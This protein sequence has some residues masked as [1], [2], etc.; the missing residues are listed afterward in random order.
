MGERLNLV[1]SGGSDYHGHMRP[2]RDLPGGKYGV[3]VP[4]EVLTELRSVRD[5]L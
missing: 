4:P 2:D 1:V 3:M 5:R